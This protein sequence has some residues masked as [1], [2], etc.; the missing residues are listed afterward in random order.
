MKPASI[1]Q[2]DLGVIGAGRLLPQLYRR[3]RQYEKAKIQTLV[4]LDAVFFLLK[5]LEVVSIMERRL[6]F[7][8]IAQQKPS[9]PVL[10]FAALR[11]WLNELTETAQCRLDASTKQDSCIWQGHASGLPGYGRGTRSAGKYSM[12]F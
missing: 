3:Q 7:G 6:L 9:S 10:S 8:R 12:I 4:R 5:S 11:G 2:L 1:S